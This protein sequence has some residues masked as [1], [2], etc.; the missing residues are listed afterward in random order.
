MSVTMS[1]IGAVHICTLLAEVAAGDRDTYSMKPCRGARQCMTDRSPV[2]HIGRSNRS[3][4]SSG[5]L[6]RL[7]C[8][9]IPLTSLER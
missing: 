8:F 2:T 5:L 1:W 4:K 9:T 6:A 3:G 7:L